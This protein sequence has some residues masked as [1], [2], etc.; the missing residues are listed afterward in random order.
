MNRSREQVSVLSRILRPLLIGVGVGI[1][2]GV[3]LLLAAAAVMVSTQVPAA[4]VTP[5]ALAVIAVTA[6]VG[7]F[8]TARLLRERGLLIGAACGLLIFLIVAIAG[9]SVDQAVQGTLLFLKLGLTVGCGAL[10]GILGVNVKR[11]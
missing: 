2:V 6:L 7:G 11:K 8:T 3:L 5:V 10:G 9:F 1:T 4:A